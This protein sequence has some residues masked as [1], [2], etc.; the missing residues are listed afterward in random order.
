MQ[1]GV[2]GQGCKGNVVKHFVFLDFVWL[3]VSR[4]LAVSFQCTNFQ[5]S[6]IVVF[7]TQWWCQQACLSLLLVLGTESRRKGHTCFNTS[8]Q[9]HNT[10]ATHSAYLLAATA[11]LLECELLVILLPSRHP[12]RK[13]RFQGD[14]LV[15]ANIPKITSPEM[16]VPEFDDFGEVHGSIP[17][18]SEWKWNSTH[19]YGMRWVYYWHCTSWSIIGFSVSRTVHN[20][21]SQWP[22]I[23]CPT[24][25][26]TADQYT[27]AR[28][29][30]LV[31]SWGKVGL[32]WFQRVFHMLESE[33]PH[34]SQTNTLLHCFCS[35]YGPPV[36]VWYERK[37]HSYVTIY[38]CMTHSYWQVTRMVS[39]TP[40]D[41][42]QDWCH[43]R[44]QFCT[45]DFTYTLTHKLTRPS[46]LFQGH[47]WEMVNQRWRLLHTFGSMCT[48]HCIRLLYWLA[49]T[50]WWDGI[51]GAWSLLVLSWS[52]LPDW[53]LPGNEYNL[54]FLLSAS[55][56]LNVLN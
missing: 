39:L 43:W 17:S 46:H 56:W 25:F 45:S 52:I 32:L 23:A 3:V 48:I 1:G 26:F 20:Y 35:A 44:R 41:K 6:T 27:G 22:R 36:R 33:N 5:M 50:I 19:R 38:R 24:V 49:W 53:I 34:L 37:Y 29:S 4:W 21:S 54:K 51:L 12:V 15:T 7:L 55:D 40:T 30:P 11:Y 13:C 16:I 42:W 14:Y 47:G 2:V 18:R 10:A 28:A 8:T 31:Q 9:S